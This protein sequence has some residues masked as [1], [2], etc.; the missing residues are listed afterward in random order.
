[1]F[2][3]G[4][5]DMIAFRLIGKSKPF[6][7]IIIRFGSATCEYN[8]IRITIDQCCYLFSGV[9]NSLSCLSAKPMRAGRITE[10]IFQVRFHGF[11]N[12][13]VQRGSGII[14]QVDLFHFRFLFFLLHR[15]TQRFL[16]KRIFT[17][18]NSLPG[19]QAGVPSPWFSV[20]NYF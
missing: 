20:S 1:M 6:N 19:R 9:F 13:F 14:I 7:G 5:N 2:D 11:N 12:L 15:V 3:G 18:W 16:I 17:P 10:I 4:C 8:L